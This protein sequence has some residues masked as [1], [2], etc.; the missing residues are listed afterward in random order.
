MPDENVSAAKGRDKGGIF[1]VDG[2]FVGKAASKQYGGACFN[3][4]GDVRGVQSLKFK[5]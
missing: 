2:Y 1:N 3:F 5:V 4:V